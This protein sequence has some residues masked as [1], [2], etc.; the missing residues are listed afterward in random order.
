[1]HHD[2]GQK[3]SARTHQVSIPDKHFSDYV[4]QD[5]IADSSYDL[6]AQYPSIAEVID[7]LQ[8]ITPR[9]DE[10]LIIG[11]NGP[12]C[13]GKTTFT[14]ALVRWLVTRNIPVTQLGFDW[15]LYDRPIRNQLVQDISL[16][17]KT[18]A[19]VTQTAWD[20]QRY[21]NLLRTLKTIK[22]GDM[23][24]VIQLTGLYDRA[25]GTQTADVAF[26][27]PFGGYVVVEGV[28]IL[29]TTNADLID[30][31]IRLD[32]DDDEILIKRAIARE[33]VKP[34]GKRLSEEY[35]RHR[36]EV[37][38][39]HHMRYLRKLSYAHNQHVVDVSNFSNIKVFSRTHA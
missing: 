27:I 13:A 36:F 24:G 20:V 5:L 19:Q 35:L 11:I 6:M 17:A 9:P 38:D 29:D 33:G 23:D 7:S 25:L 12:T 22:R 2:Q 37:M 32:V 8:L 10:V 3:L 31:H 16:G 30:S 28:A 15:F 14:E 26:T 18:I 34:P 39:L 4:L 21:G 1:M